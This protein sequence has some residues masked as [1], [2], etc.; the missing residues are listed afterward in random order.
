MTGNPELFLSRT[1][2]RQV[3][4]GFSAVLTPGADINGVLFTGASNIIVTAAAGTLTGTILHSTVV[5]SSLTS[6]GTLINLTV[7]NPI[8]GSIT[9]NSNTVTTNANLTG[10]ITSVGNIT[11]IVG[12][13]SAIIITAMLSP[14]GTTGSMTFTNGV[15]TAET[16]AT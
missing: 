1:G 2:Y 14:M 13:I 5:T 6:V 7:T 3:T 10:P 11:T 16:P 15:L 8:V 12:G 4:A 9:G